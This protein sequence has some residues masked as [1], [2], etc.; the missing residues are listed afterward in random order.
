MRTIRRT[1]LWIE[2]LEHRD[3]PAQFFVTNTNDAGA[4]HSV[5][6]LS[7]QFNLALKLFVSRSQRRQ[8]T[9]IF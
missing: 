6:P 1:E 9:S 5:R 7:A 3:V 4:G 8:P 2:K